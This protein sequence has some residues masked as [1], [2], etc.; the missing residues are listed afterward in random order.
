VA[1]IELIPLLWRHWT[2]SWSLDAGLALVALLYLQAA[3][4]VG[5]SWPWRRTASFLAGVLTV[6]V[7]LQSGLDTYDDRLLSVHMVQHLLLLELAP[8]LLLGGRPGI[9]LLR[10]TSRPRRPALARR[11]RRLRPLSSPVVCL[12]VFFAAVAGTHVSAFYDATLSHPALHDLEHVL[13]LIAGTFMWWPVLDGDPL[14]RRRLDGFGRLAYV[15]AAML[16][17][18]VLGS[19]LS[20][21]T[22]L[23]YAPYAAG[24]HSL[25]VSALQD[26]QRAGTIMWVI[27]S[28]LL[29]AAGLWQ[30]MAAMRAEERRLQSRERAELGTVA[31]E[32]RRRA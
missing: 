2:L 6:L 13:Y 19:Y 24:A 31:A 8:L 32:A 23:L 21:Y 11:L 12:A 7:A 22:G 20:R 15:I 10:G 25:G 4:R 9:L 16:P 18:T 17:M 26:Q 14:P 28:T 5:E 1:S 30:A 29:V 3:W 27:G